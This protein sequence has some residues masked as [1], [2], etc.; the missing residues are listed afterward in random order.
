VVEAGE[1]EEVLLTA[2]LNLERAGEVR[3]RMRVPQ[4]RRPELYDPTI[5]AE[6]PAPRSKFGGQEN[7][8]ATFG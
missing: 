2:E 7:S 1:A 4:D 5:W 6:P 8:D 3:E